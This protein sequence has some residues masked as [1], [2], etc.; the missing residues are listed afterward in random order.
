MPLVAL[1]RQKAV[2]GHSRAHRH[3]ASAGCAMLHVPGPAGRLRVLQAQSLS[4]LSC[5]PESAAVALHLTRARSA[6]HTAAAQEID[7][8]SESHLVCYSTAHLLLRAMPLRCC[9][10]EPSRGRL[11]PD[12][13]ATVQ[14]SGT[15][16]TSPGP[17]PSL[18]ASQNDKLAPAR[19]ASERARQ[20]I[21]RASR[22][23][24]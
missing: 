4:G 23:R 9:A 10:A 11:C 5:V 22:S 21:T 16:A 17:V 19:T 12:V 13:C 15:H 18:Q 14:C 2:P 7:W 6:G 24:T 20:G 3:C 8:A 1:L